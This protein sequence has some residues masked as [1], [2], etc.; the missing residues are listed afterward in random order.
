MDLSVQTIHF[1]LSVCSIKFGMFHYSTEC[2]LCSDRQLTHWLPWI[3][4]IFVCFY[5]NFIFDYLL[6]WQQWV[7]YPSN[8]GFISLVT[9]G[10]P[11]NKRF[12][13]LATMGFPR[14]PSICYIQC[15][16]SDNWFLSICLDTASMVCVWDSSKFPLVCLFVSLHIYIASQI[17]AMDNS[18]SCLWWALRGFSFISWLSTILDLVVA[19]SNKEFYFL[20]ALGIICEF[21]SIFNLVA[22]LDPVVAPSNKNSISCLLWV[23]S[24]RSSHFYLFQLLP[25]ATS[26]FIYILYVISLVTFFFVSIVFD[27][28]SHVTW[29][30]FLIYTVAKQLII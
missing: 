11:S 10:F 29:Y 9:K 3:I 16:H 25:M 23:Q 22:I 19:P 5:G 24:V 7:Y 27:G 13:S 8:K 20:F 1:A 15:I 2:D 21:F 14:L 12:Y 6:L 30:L 26:N 18:T 28:R 4:L 17:A